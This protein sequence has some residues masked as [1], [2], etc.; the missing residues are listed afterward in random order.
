VVLA[1]ARFGCHESQWLAV[2]G[3]SQQLLQIADLHPYGKPV[4]DMAGGM[5]I[6][7]QMQSKM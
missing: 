4:I 1:L 3:E 2:G 6:K 5:E 7:P